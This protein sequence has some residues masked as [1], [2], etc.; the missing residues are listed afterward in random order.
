MIDLCFAFNEQTLPPP[1]LIPN[2]QAYVYTNE[3]MANTIALNPESQFQAKNIA[4]YDTEMKVNETVRRF[5]RED[6]PTTSDDPF[7]H[8]DVI[9]EIKKTP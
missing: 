8:T 5:L 7:T 2:T 9:K 1:N 3:Q 4:D 6:I